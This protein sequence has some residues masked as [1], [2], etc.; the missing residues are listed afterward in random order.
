MRKIAVVLLFAAFLISACSAGVN[1]PASAGGE[2]SVAPAT[3]TT[4]ATTEPKTT[5]TPAPVTTPAPTPA[6]T[7]EP[8]A[9][10]CGYLE[11][12]YCTSGTELS[13]ELLSIMT[14]RMFSGSK[15]L[16]F[17]LPAGTP[18]F[19][20]ESGEAREGQYSLVGEVGLCGSNPCGEDA[21]YDFVSVGVASE[22]VS[23][24]AADYTLFFA[25][26]SFGARYP[27]TAPAN[28]GDVMGV[29][30]DK[31]L[32]VPLSPANGTYNLIVFVP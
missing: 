19:A 23:P 18:V 17:N 28:A 32:S 14:S 11:E 3:E 9:G 22:G 4:E 25:G 27:D 30:T 29:V 6:P 20:P 31:M 21:L 15:V 13:S 10:S 2:T 8:V 5:E 24:L 12:R 26:A 16:A 1:P 7:P